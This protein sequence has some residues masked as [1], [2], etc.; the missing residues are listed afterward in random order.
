MDP[1]ST[2]LI[3]FQKQ[4][5]AFIRDTEK[6]VLCII[7]GP[8]NN[9][10]L[11]KVLRGEEWQ[12]G[13]KS[14]LIIINTPWLDKNNDLPETVDYH[15]R[16]HYKLLME[17]FKK[18][19]VILP[20]FS[21]ALEE[22]NDPVDTIANGIIAFARNIAKYTDPPLFCWLP[23]TNRKPATWIELI[24]GL[25]EILSEHRIRLIIAIEKE[26]LTKPIEKQFDDTASFV[27][28]AVSGDAT[29]DYFEKLFAPPAAGHAA[30]T[31]S[32]SAAPDVAPP[33]RKLQPPSDEQIKESLTQLNLPPVLTT[34]QA[35][36]LRSAI[37]AAAFAAGKNDQE[38]AIREQ[39]N[40]CAIC[41]EADVKLEHAL[42]RLTLANYYLQFEMEQEAIEQYHL[43]ETIAA[44]IK[45][46]TQLAQ[47][48]MARAFIHMRKKKL[49]EEAI[50]LYEQAAAAAAIGES[51]LL[52]LESLR[53]L[54][55]CHVK[56]KDTDAAMLCW[57]AAVH[58]GAKMDKGE[59]AA[60]TFLDIS[61]QFI[62][63]LEK[64]GLDEQAQS[65][66]EIVADV[67]RKFIDESNTAA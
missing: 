45:A 13:N 43:A 48:R 4:A 55:T 17:G 21:P 8:E 67:G 14:P 59:I 28:Y 33:Q 57:K 32:G 64:E 38:T 36:A 49:L 27:T 52:Y 31:P 54:G 39:R 34:S 60:S 15:L 30:G 42:M 61:A 46:Y 41:E 9:A 40:A 35:E 16:E 10:L 19:G 58:R 11:S 44:E 53:M 50:A 29:N 66:E 24:I 51:W 12:P 56:L 65:V 22:S 26:K 37:F 25:S 7:T 18:D 6:R 47:I 62:K 5:R 2:S 63:L 23:S 3:V 1:I 20:Q